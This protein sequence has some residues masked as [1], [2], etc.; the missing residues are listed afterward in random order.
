MQWEALNR[1][2]RGMVLDLRDPRAHETLMRLVETA[3]VFM[4]NYLPDAR[5]KFAID[6]EDVR[7]RNPRIVY[8][9]GS[10]QGPKGPEREL[11][12]FDSLSFWYRSGA[13]DAVAPG[14]GQ[15]PAPIPA[16]VYGDGLSGLTLAGGI[17]A[18]LARVARTGEPSVVDVS[19][20]AT[21]MWA[22]QV[23]IM[24]S[25][26]VPYDV[27]R[28]PLRQVPG[29][30]LVRQYLTGDQRLIALSMLNP[31]P[32]W[33][34]FCHAL[35]RPDLVDD[36]RFV[37]ATVRQKHYDE[38]SAIIAAELQTRTLAECRELL[39]RQSGPWGVAQ[40]E[41][42][43]ARDPQAIA[44]GY[45]TIIEYG[46]GMTQTVVATPFQFDERSPQL[47]PAP[48]LG[49][50]TAEILTELGFSEAGLQIQNS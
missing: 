50:H 30:P 35:G 40:I 20:M 14:P 10:G 36:P 17:A 21:G 13:A 31:Q 9:R 41:Q 12:G 34:S 7:A 27:M 26:Q 38:C 24:A 1:G 45:V 39:S 44:N 48:R 23:G 4:T 32:H 18:A 16:P 19:L 15:W 3:D 28:G 11:G 42:E 37:D 8:A 6:V 5:T 22:M 46:D 29:N 33:A 47:R 49:E 2:K 25:A 43:V